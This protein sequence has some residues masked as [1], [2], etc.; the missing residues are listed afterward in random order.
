MAD[1]TR[2]DVAGLIQNAYSDTF[3]EVAGATSQVLATFP[4]IN[5]GTKTYVLPVLAT[6]PH[7][8]W[9]GEAPGT[10]GVKPTAKATWENKNLV[11][12]EVAVIVPVHE[13]VIDDA[14]ED[15]LGDIATLGGR[16]IAYALDAAVAFGTNKPASWVSPSL[17]DSA[18]AA[19]QVVEVSPTPGEDDLVGAIFQAAGMLD[20]NGY[21]ASDF[22]ARRGLRYKLANLRATD[23][24]PIYI[25]SL[26][27]TPGALDSV[28]GLTARWFKGTVFGDVQVWD[29]ADAT[30]LVV[31]RD[32]VR[33]GVRQDI[34][35]KFLDQATVG[36]INLAENDM[37][38]LRFKARYAYVLGD[39]MAENSTA[40][41]TKSP[42]AAVGST[43]ES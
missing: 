36:G 38:A 3:H 17:F 26:S 43:D 10:T 19:D 18:D 23:G 14:N 32:R 6:V 15:I 27:S 29:S 35:V 24:T 2:E 7:A 21:E 22:L 42:V 37:I 16:A 20:D 28:A 25:P 12:E 33:I 13:N 9:I 31:D 4:T 8:K 41:V 34:T 11:A 1:I 39:T 40:S 30:A 5:M